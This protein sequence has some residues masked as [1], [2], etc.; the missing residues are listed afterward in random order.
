MTQITIPVGEIGTTRVFALSMTAEQ[1]RKLR[2]EPVLMAGALGA[3]PENPNGV[4]V[5]PLTDLGDLGLA[6]FLRDGIDAHPQDIARDQAKLA[7]LDGWVM[8]VH[9]SAFATSGAT[10]DPIPALTLIGTYAQTPAATT[11]V[12]LE[13]EAAQPYT[14]TPMQDADAP[15]AAKARGSWIVIALALIVLGALWIALT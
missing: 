14:G 9:S 10:L 3:E 12:P 4:E 5:F 6:G 7:A 2:D 1:A 15:P 13:A 8:L 11:Q